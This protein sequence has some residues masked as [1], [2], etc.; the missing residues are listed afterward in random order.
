[1]LLK[2]CLNGARR[3]E[4]HPALP[5]T[6]EQIAAE[7][8][9]A[10]AA[11]AGALHAHPRGPDGA[12]SLEPEHADAVVRALREACPGVPVGLT[13]GLWA[14]PGVD[15]R[16]AMIAG[17]TEL[18]DFVSVNMSEDGVDGLVALL[19]DRGIGIEAGLWSVD[20]ARRLSAMADWPRFLRVLVESDLETCRAIDA[21]IVER[22]LDLPQLHH[23]GDIGT[24][25]V[26]EAAIA[27]GHDIRVGLEDTLVL[28]DGSTARDNAELVATAAAMAAG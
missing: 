26:L 24:W 22:L 1:V 14:T 16:H 2:C 13:T 7:G 5:V 6:P 10:V 27:A 17:W 21:F 28:P 25:A 20:D 23:G 4:D 3:A 9:K 11:G 15:E 18:P 19:L 12:E 8:A